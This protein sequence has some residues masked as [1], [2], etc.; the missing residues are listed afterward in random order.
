MGGK[1][2]KPTTTVTIAPSQ[3]ETGLQAGV[4]SSGRIA[5]V[6]RAIRSGVDLNAELSDPGTPGTTGYRPLHWAARFDN[7]AAIQ[8]IRDAVVAA[9][10]LGL[11]PNVKNKVKHGTPLHTAI[12]Y[13]ASAKTIAALLALPGIEPNTRDMNDDT[14]LHYL[15]KEGRYKQD[16]ERRK[17]LKLLVQHGA[18]PALVNAAGKTAYRVIQEAISLEESG[19]LRDEYDKV[20]SVEAGTSGGGGTDEGEEALN[21]YEVLIN[22][23]GA[24]TA[25]STERE[26][27]A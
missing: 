7:A 19:Y 22:D 26:H 21:F 4:K 20:H 12:E 2:S 13:R 27:S 24:P 14:P 8:A 23:D 9:P 16:G 6:T 17:V 3:K 1:S 15:K 11:E 18:K 5:E 25:P 10:A